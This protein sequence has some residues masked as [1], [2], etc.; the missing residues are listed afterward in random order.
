MLLGKP[1]NRSP[2][3]HCCTISKRMGG[4]PAHYDAQQEDREDESAARIRRPDY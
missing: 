2:T 1:H 3:I 4:Q